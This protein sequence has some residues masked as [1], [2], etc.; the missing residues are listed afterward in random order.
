MQQIT[1]VNN[2]VFADIHTHILPQMDDGAKSSEESIKLLM[3]LERQGV[4]DVVFS[5]HFDLSKESV[6]AFCNR[7]EQC[8]KSL[9]DSI[10]EC[11]VCLKI[12][13]HLAAEV[14]Y[15]PNLIF[16]DLEPLCI[17][18]TDYLLLELTNTFPFNF[19]NT[20]NAIFSKGK[21]PVLAHIERYRYLYSDL[22]LLGRL[23]DDGVVMQCN[24]SAFLNF[25]SGITFKKLLK[26][27]YVHLLA[28]DTHDLLVRPPK[29]K[30]AL[31]KLKKHKEF[32]IKNSEKLI[33]NKIV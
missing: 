13:F 7:R 25:K 2:T 31:N 4:T 29:L 30:E 26:N 15:D 3:E 19:E 14:R 16:S 8:Y 20:L 28:S 1:Q 9:M 17:G 22:K 33:T 21:F 23:I 12:K 24:A 18:D 11:G 27:G 32:L 6:E 5:P 10:A